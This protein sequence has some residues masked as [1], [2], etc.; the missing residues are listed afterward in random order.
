MATKTKPARNKKYSQIRSSTQ[1]I[2]FYAKRAYESAFF[3]GDKYHPPKAYNTGVIRQYLNGSDVRIAQNALIDQ[4]AGNENN[5]SLL[6]FMFFDGVDGATEVVTASSITESITLVEYANGIN[7]TIEQ[8]ISTAISESN[9]GSVTAK[10]LIT[11]GYFFSH[12]THNYD[13]LEPELIDRFFLT[14]ISNFH[15][16]ALEVTINSKM[17][18]DTIISSTVLSANYDPNRV[19]LSGMTETM[20]A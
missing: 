3:I 18:M 11:Y 12:L 14:D 9:D 16:E 5:W 10:N 4:L 15:P 13:K 8:L 2:S 7:S 1:H 17:V 6:L 20:T 19:V